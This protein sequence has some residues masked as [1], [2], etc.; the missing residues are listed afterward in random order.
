VQTSA[1][2]LALAAGLGWSASPLPLNPGA[3]AKGRF[4]YVTELEVGATRMEIPSTREISLESQAGEQ[5]LIVKT[6]SV[7]GMG[8]TIDRLHLDARSMRPIRRETR[9]R[10]GRLQL[11]YTGEVV[12]GMIQSAGQ[13]IMVE[14]A[15]DQPAYAGDAGLDTLLV[16]LQLSE[17]LSGRLFVIE[18]DVE[19]HLVNFEFSVQAVES[20]TVPAGT[21]SAW[22]IRLQ[23]IDDPDYRQIIWVSVDEPR[24]FL[25]GR[26][27]VPSQAG[28]G[29][30]LTQLVDR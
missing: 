6:T 9:Q 30:V 2:A 28:G 21:F 25:Q 27:P 8:E 14:Q 29:H 17:G 23:A 7:T 22:P 26:A 4:H 3:I 12:T 16:G 15:V 13:T 5:R 24:L 11:E 1:L 10:Q 18:T 19:V 20:I